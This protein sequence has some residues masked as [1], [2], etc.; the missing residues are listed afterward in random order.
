MDMVNSLI[1]HLPPNMAA[2]NTT[3]QIVM[4]LSQLPCYFLPLQQ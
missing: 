2:N 1:R 4:P 3:T